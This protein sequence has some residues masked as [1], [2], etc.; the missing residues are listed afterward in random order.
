MNELSLSLSLLHVG[1]DRNDYKENYMHY[2]K[3]R[4]LEYI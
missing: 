4:R 3:I 1:V 2:S